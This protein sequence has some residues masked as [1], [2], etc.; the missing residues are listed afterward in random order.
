MPIVF[1]AS[2]EPWLNAMNA[3]DSD[4]QPPEPVVDPARVGPPEHVQQRRP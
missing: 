3:A 2:F 1:W 4:L